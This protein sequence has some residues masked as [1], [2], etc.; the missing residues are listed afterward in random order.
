M[1]ILK[2]VFEWFTHLSPHDDECMT[3]TV[4]KGKS[5][6]AIAEHITGDE[7]RWK[8]LA[9]ANP[10]KGWDEHYTLQVGEILKLP[11]SWLED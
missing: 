8:E 7:R 4:R 10:D 5:L 2:S 11:H 9:D 6:S 3:V 1:S